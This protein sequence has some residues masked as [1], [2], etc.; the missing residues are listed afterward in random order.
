VTAVESQRES[1]KYLL[2][3]V[4][5]WLH[6]SPSLEVSGYTAL[7]IEQQIIAIRKLRTR[8]SSSLINIALLG[9]FS[10]GKS[11]LIGGLQGK[12]EYTPVVG[13]DGLEFEHYVGL[14]HSASKAT[15]ACPA[16]VVP[17]DDSADLDATGRGFLRVCFTDDPATWVDIGNSP[18]PAVVAAYTTGDQRAIA[19]GRENSH[20][21]RTVAE[22]EILL[23]NPRMPAKLF[24]LPGTESLHA[25]HDRIA[26][27]AWLDADCFL[28]VTQATRTLSAPDLALIRRLHTHHRSS[29]KKVVWVMTGIDRATMTNYAG[30]PEWKDALDQNN[31][32]LRTNFPP[33][34]GARDTFVGLDGFMAVSPAWEAR[35]I[36]EREHGSPVRGEKLIAA[37]RMD[38]LRRALADL[39]ES[40]TGRRHLISAAG[41]AQAII[42]PRFRELVEILDSARLPLAELADERARLERRHS[43]L[44]SAIHSVRDQLEGALRDHVRRVERSF[45]GLAEHLHSELDSRIMSADM[46]KERETAKIEF[47]Q[48]QAMQEWVSA[49][50]NR[51]ESVWQRE[52]DSF[53][54]G[55]LTTVRST[56][57]DSASHESFGELAGRVD[58]DQLKIP[59][60]E[61]YRADTQDVIQRISGVVGISSFVG[62]SIAA[63][64]GVLTGGLIAI[65]IGVTMAAGLAYEG[66]RRRK[67]RQTARDHLRQEWTSGLDEVAA[68]YRM[69]YLAAATARGAEVVARSVELL[70]ERHD[71]L[72]RKMIMVDRRLAQPDNVDKNAVVAMLEPYCANGRELLKQLEKFSSHSVSLGSGGR[73][74]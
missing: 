38:L 24:D 5:I 26:N 52:F 8:V 51:P 2:D 43:Q 69:S 49:A 18:L 29:R 46:T 10:S 22:V 16:T 15:T 40:G 67:G 11:F 58:L 21:E 7:E 23:E 70:S 63:A 31:E 4:S 6:A 44:K 1:L 34:S 19:E 9:S 35:G 27:N 73:R 41:E 13:E 37:S 65:P 60:T 59:P 55:A 54:E 56:L 30:Q 42:S 61:K 72:S 28:F 12:L 47:E 39:I 66:L 14:L 33:P 57:A 20:R 17:V 48:T 53:V 50:G 74:S 45:D 25:I 68:H 71:E 32:Y 64:T 62:G 36:W 3:Q